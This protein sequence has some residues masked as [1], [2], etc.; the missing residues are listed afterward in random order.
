[1]LNI[2]ISKAQLSSRLR[3]QKEIRLAFSSAVSKSPAVCFPEWRYEWRVWY[4]CWVRKGLRALRIF[5]DPLRKRRSDASRIHSAA[6]D[7]WECGFIQLQWRI[8]PRCRF[9]LASSAL[10]IS[11]W[12]LECCVFWMRS[13]SHR[14][15]RVCSS[16]CVLIEGRR[17][18]TA[19]V[20]VQ[21]ELTVFYQWS[22]LKTRHVAFF[23]IHV[24]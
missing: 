9:S 6:I 15:C 7:R 10:I 21:E 24:H 17:S 23:N 13:D 18:L 22:A 2:L 16:D 11:S 12:S 1:M 5:P 8:V 19:C 4:S 20:A 14:S 3:I